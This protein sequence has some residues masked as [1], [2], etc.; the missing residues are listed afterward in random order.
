MIS[1]N[2]YH[3]LSLQRGNYS[4]M[5]GGVM[6]GRWRGGGDDDGDD[7]LQF[8]VPAGCQ[9]GV[10]DPR[11]RVFDGGGAL[12]GFLE[13]ASIP[14][15]FLGQR[16]L[17]VRRGALGATQGGHTTPGRGKG[18]PAPWVRVV[19]LCTLLASSSGSVGLLEK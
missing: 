11:N 1:S 13:K 6:D 12:E 5:D 17:V 8:P 18:P 19:P 14:P 4:H 2:P 15:K 9:N 16:L 10:S 7:L 3:P